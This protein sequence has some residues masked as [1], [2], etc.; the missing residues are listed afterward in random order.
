MSRK[1]KMFSYAYLQ[2]SIY[3]FTVFFLLLLFFVLG[4]FMLFRSNRCPLFAKA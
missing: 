2:V 4:F 3:Y 1:D